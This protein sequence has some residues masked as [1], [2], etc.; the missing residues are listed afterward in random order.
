LEALL[1][2][3]DLIINMLS[4]IGYIS[5]HWDSPDTK[6]RRYARISCALLILLAVVIPVIVLVVL[7][8]PS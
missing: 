1:G 7:K 3:I 2:L 5:Q 6:N 8:S 4:A